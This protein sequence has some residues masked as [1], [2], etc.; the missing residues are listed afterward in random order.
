MKR[1][2]LQQLSLSELVDMVLGLQSQRDNHAEGEARAIVVEDWFADEDVKPD[3]TAMLAQTDVDE[4]GI[5]RGDMH[6]EEEHERHLDEQL[7]RTSLLL[8]LSI[9]FRETLEPTTIVERMLHVM[10]N[11]LGISNA[12]VVLI[13]QDGA[14]DLAM[15][16]RNGDM[17]QVT[18]MV[19]RAVLDRGLAG[20]ALRH[21]RSVVLPDVSRDKR[22]IPYSEWQTTGSAIVLPIRQAQTTLGVLTIYHPAPNHFSSRDMLLMEGVAAQAGVSL[23]AARRY[24]EESTRREQALALFSM[25]QFLTAERSYEDL[26]AMLQEK[27]AHIF[28]VDHSL[29]FLAS[30]D[31][32]LLTIAVPAELN[33]PLNRYL[34]KQVAASAR[35][36]W[37]QR[38]ILTET[39]T[40]QNPTRAWMALPLLHSGTAIGAV[41]M[42][43]TRGSD[44]AFSANMWSMLTT[45]T[46]VIAANCANKRLVEQ[47]RRYN[48]SLENLV[49]ERTFLVQRSRDFLRVVFDTMPEGLVLLDPQEVLLAANHAFCYGI[50]GRHPRTVVG[51]NLPAIW[52]EL[53]QRG[54]MSIEMLAPSDTLRC[55][56]LDE[57]ECR[58]MRVLC[59]NAQG[60][61][62]W[63]EV[64]R[65]AVLDSTGEIDYY[66]ERW[67]DSTRRE[68]LHR[69]MIV[70][71]Q[72]NILGHL[73]SRVVHD[74]GEP[75]QAAVVA[76]DQ[77]RGAEEYA[78]TGPAHLA[79]AH[80]YLLR[81]ERTL[82]SLSHLYEVPRTEWSCINVN[83]LLRQVE[84][85]AAPQFAAQSV[86]L[87]LDL[88][89]DVPSIYGQPDALRQVLMGVLFNAQEA[90]P[91]GGDIVVCSRRK[92]DERHGITYC[93][94]TVR[95][96]GA[97][98]TPEQTKHLFEPFKSTKAQGVG[99]GLY[100]SKQIIEQHAG[101]IG[102][103]SKTGEGTIVEIFL[104]WNRQCPGDAA[105]P[106]SAP[107]APSAPSE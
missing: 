45:F 47:Q 98:M 81:I 15:S 103:V 62:R 93:F 37:E 107:S 27:S 90:M 74:I 63:Y 64:D 60:Q 73:T 97:G 11:N 48:E 54:E 40:P 80:E 79:R 36:A 75:L 89:D 105:T 26:A 9:E 18:A 1:E 99:I 41:V 87:L 24:Q 14:V 68:E 32:A 58:S 19:T 21:G 86:R 66:V 22:W 82:K 59:S 96:S 65:L 20:W 104:P 52:E 94:I 23:G 76:L 7:R 35:Q 39:D 17:Q 13:G 4:K 16:L 92:E 57:T 50:I 12:S 44:I 43:R 84:S 78:E 29:L 38:T 88:D 33:Q 69:H 31:K 56:D 49:E 5:P 77:A 8:Q 34:L 101:S 30:D 70:Q 3:P 46:N 95:D 85:V 67:L 71:D 53:E 106:A 61:R 28:G 10:V 55:L 83:E 102:V 42:L 72:R 25:S 100:L 91:A 6:D 2:E 51:E